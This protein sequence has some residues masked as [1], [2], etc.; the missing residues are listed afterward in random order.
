MEQAIAEMEEKNWTHRDGVGAWTH[1]D[2]GK[3]LDG[4]RERTDAGASEMP[5]G[6]RPANC[7]TM[8]HSASHD[9]NL[10]RTMTVVTARFRKIHIVLA[11]GLPIDKHSYLYSHAD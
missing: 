3:K 2:G 9:G 6:N 7:Q 8:L 11:I 4:A 5:V 10:V 1:R